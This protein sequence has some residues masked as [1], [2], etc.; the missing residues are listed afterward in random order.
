M[1]PCYCVTAL[2]GFPQDEKMYKMA[3]PSKYTPEL[4]AR[5]DKLIDNMSGGDKF[6]EEMPIMDSI[7]YKLDVSDVT[8]YAWCKKHET[9]LNSIK[10]WQRKRNHHFVGLASSYSSKGKVT[11]W[12][13]LAK[14][15][16]RFDDVY[17]IEDESEHKEADI[18]S[19]GEQFKTA[20]LLEL[21]EAEKWGVD[22]VRIAKLRMALECRK[23]D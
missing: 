18:L 2:Y 3:R 8:L 23:S 4:Q 13:F 19:E 7:A 21:T 16:L 5:F 20:V 22:P 6:F 14:N 9:F 17:K 12:I 1:L 11:M 15:I 10:R